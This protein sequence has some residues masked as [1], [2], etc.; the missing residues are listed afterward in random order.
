MRCPRFRYSQG[1]LHPPS[2][3]PSPLQFYGATCQ[4]SAAAFCASCSAKMWRQTF[5]HH[6]MSHAITSVH[7]E[8]QRAPHAT[9]IASLSHAA[10]APR[11]QACSSVVPPAR[12]QQQPS[13]HPAPRRAPMRSVLHLLHFKQAN[14]NRANTLQETHSRNAPH[15][16]CIASCCHRC[17]VRI[18]QFCGATCQASAAA[19]C[20]CCSAGV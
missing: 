1:S 17:H 5:Y 10:T 18:L 19:F 7:E 16:V 6:Q 13:A 2:P 11:E 4:A 14:F 9:C 8:S 3:L 12:H 20:A 15:A